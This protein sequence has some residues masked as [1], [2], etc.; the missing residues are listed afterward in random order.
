MGSIIFAVIYNLSPKKYIQ[1]ENLA[2]FYKTPEKKCRI[3]FVWKD[4]VSDKNDGEI[5]R[6]LFSAN[7]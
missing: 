5:Y 3:V 6:I 2:S 7:R 4:S 1:Y